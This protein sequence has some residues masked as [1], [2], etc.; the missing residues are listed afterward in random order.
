LTVKGVTPVAG[1]DSPFL[2]KKKPQETLEKL[3]VP[4]QVVLQESKDPCGESR[5]AR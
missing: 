4:N 2:V 5:C 3:Q 1:R